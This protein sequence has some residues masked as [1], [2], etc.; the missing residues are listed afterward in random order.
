MTTQTLLDK[1]IKDK[2]G[3]IVIWQFP[4]APLI[5]WMGFKLMRYLPMTTPLKNGRLFISTA[6]LFT[7]A[8]LEITSGVNYLRR[9]IG[10]VVMASIILSTIR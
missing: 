5:G 9:I 1:C 4:N 7:W 6:F 3:K 8:Y 2:H 10:V